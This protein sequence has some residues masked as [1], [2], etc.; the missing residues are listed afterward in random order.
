M[1]DL[2]VQA[3]VRVAGASDPLR[4]LR[5][6]SGNFPSLA[7]SLSKVSVSETFKFE[8]QSNTQAM[9]ALGLQGNVFAVVRDPTI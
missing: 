6:V 8:V 1:K 2:G 7:K 4:M 3:A 9:S 5:D